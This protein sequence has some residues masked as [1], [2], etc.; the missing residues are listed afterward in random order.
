[1]YLGELVEQG[2]AEQV[3]AQPRARRTRDY[4]AGAFG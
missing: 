4:V 2:Q 3:F 1:M